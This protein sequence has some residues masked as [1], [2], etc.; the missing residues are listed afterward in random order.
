MGGGYNVSDT[1]IPMIKQGEKAS[2][3]WVFRMML[4]LE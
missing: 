4:G 2:Q 1:T 3:S